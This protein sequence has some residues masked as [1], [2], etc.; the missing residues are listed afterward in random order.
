MPL[1]RLVSVVLPIRLSLGVWGGRDDLVL[2]Y[3]LFVVPHHESKDP[4]TTTRRHG[5]SQDSK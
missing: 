1:F 5:Q 2:I 3:F 4:L